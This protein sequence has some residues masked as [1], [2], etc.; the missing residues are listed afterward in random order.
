MS[1]LLIPRKCE[2]AK[3]PRW[4]RVAFAARCARRVL[5]LFQAGWPE[6]PT[7]RIKAVIK[8]VEAAERGPDGSHIVTHAS[9]AATAASA[10]GATI[11]AK[12]ATVAAITTAAVKSAA[13]AATDAAAYVVYMAVDAAAEAAASTAA[14]VAIRADFDHLVA[15]SIAE[16]WTDQTDVTPE[17]F[18]PLW[19]AGPPEGWPPETSDVNH[20]DQWCQ[21]KPG[22]VPHEATRMS[23]LYRKTFPIVA[24][25]DRV[26]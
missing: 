8:A 7:G 5:P 2:I 11:A 1:K 9:A 6:A 21:G 19:P 16:G 14:D 13:N 12:M 17:V 10:R 26:Y 24:V 3:L 22:T 4:A 23:R 18:G 25:Y 15:T 20:T